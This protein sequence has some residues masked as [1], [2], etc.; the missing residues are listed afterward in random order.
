MDRKKY[1]D[2]T[3]LPPKK[4]NQEEP[5]I[6][7]DPRLW[8]AHN[9]CLC[10]IV[11]PPRTGKSSLLLSIFGNSNFLRFYYDNI[12]MIGSSINQDE[13]LAPLVAYYNNTY[14]YLNNKV[15]DDIIKFQ[16]SQDKDTK[17][18]AAI[19][20]DD[21][22]SLANFSSTSSKCKSLN[23]LAGNYRHILGAK[24]KGGGLFIS[25]QKIKSI[26][27][28]LR[29]CANVILLGRISNRSEIEVIVD[30]WADVFGGKRCFLKMLKY[31]W[32]PDKYNF[33]CLYI[34]GS[35]EEPRPCIYKS[36]SE[37][38]FPDDPRFKPDANILDLMSNDKLFQTKE[39]ITKEEN[40]EE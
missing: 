16:N 15:I 25:T 32:Y 10:L 26:P 33:A 31:C 35:I 22:L 8:N 39:N 29:C 34:D 14:D 38:I 21:A 9:S 4:T 24:R 17:E 1:K 36:F 18:S 40:I 2:L 6:E 19:I 28:N 20:I 27:T 13:T 11:S 23:S 3:L 12:Y 7:I 5:E 37:K 30:L